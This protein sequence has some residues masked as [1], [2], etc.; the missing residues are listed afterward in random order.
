MGKYDPPRSELWFRLFLGVVI[1]GMVVAGLVYRGFEGS[2]ASL[3]A[4]ITGAIFGVGA[5]AWC[6]WKLFGPRSG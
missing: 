2:P 4:V 1:V 6:L 5:V 3:E